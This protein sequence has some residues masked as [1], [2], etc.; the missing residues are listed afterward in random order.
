VKINARFPLVIICYAK[1]NAPRE[2][3]FK[4]TEN[5][6]FDFFY[7]RKKQQRKRWRVFSAFY[8]IRDIKR[9]KRECGRD[10]YLLFLFGVV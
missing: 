8:F 7:E 10:L 1:N 6:L 9:K 2:F 5:N 3:I 4:P